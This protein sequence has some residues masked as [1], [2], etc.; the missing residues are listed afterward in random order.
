MEGIQKVY[1]FLN[2][3]QNI[4]LATIENDQPRVRVYGASILF[5]GK[6]YFMAIK[7]SNAP[8]QLAKN[9]KFEICTFKNIVLRMNGK[10]VLD[11]RS[12][13]KQALIKK[14]PA[15]GESL[16][17][18]NMLMYYVT[19]ATATFYNLQGVSDVINF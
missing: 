17:E 10:L 14:I 18:E 3:A 12:E 15:L 6:L 13:V 5:E 9:P 7:N 2:R 11:D 4:Y 16:G 8:K 19:D 1:D